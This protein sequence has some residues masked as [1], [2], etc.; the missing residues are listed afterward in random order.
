MNQTGCD[1]HYLADRWH[2][3]PV[4]CV[5]GGGGEFEI[6]QT[7]RREAAA[8]PSSGTDCLSIV[9]CRRV[10]RRT[11]GVVESKFDLVSGRPNTG[12]GGREGA[13]EGDREAPHTGAPLIHRTCQHFFGYF[14]GTIFGVFFKGMFVKLFWDTFFGTTL[15][16]IVRF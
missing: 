8:T 13:T 3:G 6:N 1:I 5:S 14:F 15:M 10:M 4:Y 9:V 12:L 11:V 7:M 2:L 16:H